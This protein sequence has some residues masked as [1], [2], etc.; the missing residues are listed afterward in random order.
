[1]KHLLGLQLGHLFKYAEL[2]EVIRQNDKLFMDLLSKVRGGNTDND[3]EQLLKAR[4]TLEFDKNYPKDA[5]HIC[6]ENEPAMKRNEAVLNNLPDE[7]YTIKANDKIPVNCKYSLALI[8]AA[9]N[10]KQTNT[11]GLENL[12]KLK[13]GAKVILMVNLDR[14]V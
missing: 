12:L 3:V 8:K 13:I 11:G 2:T 7:L 1:M 14:V 9:Q 10:Q 4:F 5:L 6:A